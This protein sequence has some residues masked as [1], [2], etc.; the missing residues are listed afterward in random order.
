MVLTGDVVLLHVVIITAPPDAISVMM[1]MMMIIMMMVLT[2]RIRFGN[3]KEE[4]DG[5]CDAD[6]KNNER[7]SITCQ[8]TVAVEAPVSSLMDVV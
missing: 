7:A 4:H 2:T 3:D 8:T 1:I 5:K 6:N